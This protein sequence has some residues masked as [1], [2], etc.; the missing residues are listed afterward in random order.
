MEREQLTE[1][2]IQ[3]FLENNIDVNDKLDSDLSLFNIDSITY[4]KIIVQI[5]S[6][7]DV[8]FDDEKLIIT[9]FYDVNS[10]VDYICIKMTAC[11]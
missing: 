10:V 7:F 11:G 3:I 8:E 9:T 4:I 5:E 2:L 1:L 6:S